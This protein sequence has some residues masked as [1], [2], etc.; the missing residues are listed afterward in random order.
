MN[1]HFPRQPDHLAANA[2]PP[3]Q[4]PHRRRLR[5]AGKH[6]RRF[7]EKYKEQDP[8]RYTETVAKVLASG[9]TPAGSHRP[10]MVKEVLEILAPGPGDIIVDCTLGFGGHA[11]EILPL[12]QPNGLL[13][14]L[15]A[16]PLELPKTEAR[17][18]ALGFDEAN[19]RA[20]RSNFAGLPKALAS[21]NI[22]TPAV[23]GLFADLGVSSM[24]LDDPARGFSL[25][26]RGPL[27]MRMNPQR[28][29]SA[30][31]LLQKISAH[32]LATALAENADEPHAHRLAGALAG[33]LFSTTTELAQAVRDTLRSS[34]LAKSKDEQDAS[35]R[36]V[37]QALRI[38]VNNELS[39][40]ESLLRELPAVLQPG[41]RAVILTFHSG[42]DRRVKKAF[43][44]GLTAGLYREI[45]Q[46][47]VRPTAIECHANPRSASAKLRWAV[48][49]D[50]KNTLSR[51]ADR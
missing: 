26:F 12:I 15:D 16:D 3:A 1:E 43:A 20:V 28:G 22:D 7:D 9:K 4:Q 2:A 44:E 42:E 48:R 45:S 49:A 19:F 18:R 10:I 50:A 38:A 40:L 17:L 13:I 14:G 35:I 31:A 39:A 11:R 24:Q 27:D 41:G 30:S 46:E 34:S 36:G 51:Q 6:P 5:Y 23:N 47:I 8:Q 21:T 33:K 37:F 32:E 29:Q 25:K